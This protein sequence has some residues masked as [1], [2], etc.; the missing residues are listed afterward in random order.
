[1]VRPMR[2]AWCEI[3]LDAL[4]ANGERLSQAANAPLLAIMKA[5]AYGHGAREVTRRLA[6]CPWFW[7][8]GVA[9]LDE[10]R[11]L[12]EG[13]Y[14]GPLLVLG[15]LVPEEA[16]QAV[17]LEAGVAISTLPVARA[18]SQAAVAGGGS[19]AVQLKVD[20]GMFRFGVPWEEAEQA[21]R[22]I[23]RLPGL[24]F[25]GILGHLG[26]A[27]RDDEDS[28][29][30]THRE[31]ERFAALVADLRRRYGPLIAHLANSSTLLAHNGVA[32]DLARP[33]LALYGWKP[34][35]W[36]PDSV[37]LRPAL[38][39]RARVAVVK[40][41]TAGARVGY[42][43]TPVQAGRRLGVL[44]IGY[45]DG[46]PRRLGLQGGY[47]RFATGTAPMVGSVSMDSCVVDLTELS[48]EGEGSTA[49]VLGAGP[50]GLISPVEL[51]A[52]SGLSIYE[53]LVGLSLR[54]PRIHD[55]PHPGMTTERGAAACP[56]SRGEVTFQENPFHA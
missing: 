5:D 21:A 29:A 36:M 26:A 16:P 27:H 41:T 40:Q 23:A 3:N 37:I 42:S 55:S 8:A 44:P 19:I 53:V 51:A 43:A 49:L 1:M 46:L 56:R 54:L 28:R 50:E 11:W 10:V 24:R 2:P 25:E 13:G 7:G 30:R 38:A 22:S 45:G 34:A 15:G 9:R 47:V 4:E 12:R 48:Q 39:V 18:L 35:P 20:L 17:A 52:R 14:R 31:I 6:D 33:G 32:F